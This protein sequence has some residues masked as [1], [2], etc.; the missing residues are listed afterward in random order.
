MGT[1]RGRAVSVLIAALILG[2]GATSAGATLAEANQK[3]NINLRIGVAAPLTGN[4][5]SIGPGQATGARVATQ[6]IAQALK[7]TGNS[8]NVKVTIAGV[9]DTQGDTT[10]A[11]QAATKLATTANIDVLVGSCATRET[12]AIAQSVTVR[13]KIV[14]ISMCSAAP[15]LS[16]L[17]D[18]GYVWQMIYPNT[19]LAAAFVRASQ[20]AFGRAATVN[21]GSINDAGNGGFRIAFDRAWKAAGGKIGQSVAWNLAQ[22]TYDTEAQRIASGNPRGWVIVTTPED[23]KKLGPALV[24]TGS[25]SPAR[26]IVIEVF[27]DPALLQELGDPATAGLRGVSPTNEGSPSKAAFDRLFKRYAR[28]SKPTGFDSLGFDPVVAAFLASLQ[29][30]SDDPAKIKQHLRSISGPPGVKIRPNQLALA[31]RTILAGKEVDYEGGWGNL[32]WDKKGDP[33]S[34]LFEFWRYPGGGAPIPPGQIINA[35]APK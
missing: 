14:Q 16:N 7:Q 3:P 22:P 33:G 15:E 29:A 17:K 2:L 18:N 28:S 24:R 25:W 10:P 6:V 13:R 12:L 21:T 26:T 32:D 5:S 35:K 31:I 11:V 20:I 1:F 30:R 8:K 4:L 27:R 34:S 19:L 9:E 23:W